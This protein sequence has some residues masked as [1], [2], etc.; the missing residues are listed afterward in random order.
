M[1]RDPS[2]GSVREPVVGNPVTEII[3]GESPAIPVVA[4]SATT[5]KPANWGLT[6]LDKQPRPEPKKAPT[7]EELAAH[8]SQFNLG[9]KPKSAS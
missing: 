4:K 8:Y 2:D 9:F 5:E 7:K 3:T 1:I 6:S